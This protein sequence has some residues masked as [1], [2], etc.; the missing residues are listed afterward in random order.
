MG[1]KRDIIKA[2]VA[3]LLV[4]GIDEEVI[5]VSKGSAIEVESEL[6]KEAIVKFLTKVNFTIT[7][8][9]ANVILEDFKI[10]PQLADIQPVVQVTP[11]QTV[12]AGSPPGPGS[13]TAPGILQG[14][15]NGV[16]TQKMDIEKDAGGLDSTGYVYI[17]DNPDS[18]GSFDVTDK[19]GQMRFTKVKLIREN[20][21]KDLL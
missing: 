15:K 20:I 5:D 14:S 12:V 8:L 10:P 21:N 3:G 17:G 2:K 9:K 7:D 11:G 19:D 18:Q 6:I 1:L 16:L 4:N 13:T